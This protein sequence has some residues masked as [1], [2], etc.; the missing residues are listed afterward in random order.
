MAKAKKKKG[1]AMTAFGSLSGLGGIKI[2]KVC[3]ETRRKNKE[4]KVVTSKSC[5]AVPLT[6]TQGGEV[7]MSV[8]SRTV[9]RDMAG[10]SKPKTAAKPRKA[11]KTTAKRKVA[12]PKPRKTAAKK[13]KSK[14]GMSME[15]FVKLQTKYAKSVPIGK[16]AI[17]RA[18]EK[19]K[20]PS[21]ALLKMAGLTKKDCDK[22][23]K[24]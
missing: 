20:Y 12:V 6:I 2:N 11:R 14:K 18:A 9:L 4:G 17:C 24:A 15:T 21:A 5:K 13:G 1:G 22:A 16:R 3:L 10:K 7:K 23:L 19:G 8:S